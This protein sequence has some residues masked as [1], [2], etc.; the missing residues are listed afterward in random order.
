MGPCGLYYLC[1][2][3]LAMD[4]AVYT[5][6]IPAIVFVVVFAVVF[7]YF[8]RKGS[9]EEWWR[10]FGGRVFR[11]GLVLFCVVHLALYSY[12]FGAVTV[13]TPALAALA[14]LAIV[15]F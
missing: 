13:I 1:N 7:P 6:L 5:Q 8:V 14:I 4:N 12:R 2:R 15:W 3:R 11:V 10:L 9:R